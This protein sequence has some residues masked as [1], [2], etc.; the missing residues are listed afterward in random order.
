[1]QLPSIDDISKIQIDEM[2]ISVLFLEY[3]YFSNILNDSAHLDRCLFLNNI[4][5]LVY[6]LYI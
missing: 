3:L 4:N 5:I 1:M 2:L 6:A